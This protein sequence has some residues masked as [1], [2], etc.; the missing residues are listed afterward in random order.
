MP[1]F[2]TLFNANGTL[3]PTYIGQYTTI[4]GYALVSLINLTENYRNN[5]FLDFGIY[6]TN[7][8]N[9]TMYAKLSENILYWYLEGSDPNSAAMQWNTASKVYPY[10]ALG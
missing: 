8:Y 4:T 7:G 2:F 3:S 1:K 5:V 9:S 6:K 10:L